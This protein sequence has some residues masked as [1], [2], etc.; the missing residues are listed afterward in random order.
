MLLSNT[1]SHNF[2]TLIALST[3]LQQLVARLKR[4]PL[5]TQVCFRFCQLVQSANSYLYRLVSFRASEDKTIDLI[6]QT[7]KALNLALARLD[8]VFTELREDINN[9][10]DRL[11]KVL[12]NDEFVQLELMDESEY[13]DKHFKQNKFPS[14]VDF[15]DRSARLDIYFRELLAIPRIR[16]FTFSLPLNL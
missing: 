11:F 7:I 9:L 12:P 13:I 14:F 8:W 4:K 1:R 2:N 3:R 5:K 6:K 10:L 15:L 16:T